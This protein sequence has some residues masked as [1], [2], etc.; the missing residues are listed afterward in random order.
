MELIIKPT[1]LCNFNCEFCSASNLDISHP[2]NGVPKEIKDLILK[3]KPSTIILTGG[4]PL[5][6][7]PDYI[8]EIQE[9]A[10]DNTYISLTSNMKDFYFNPDKWRDV[11]NH[12]HI[13]FITSFNYGHT[14]RWD[15]NTV[16]DE[17][18]FKKVTNKFKEITGGKSLPFIA[19]IDESNEEFIMDHIYLAKELN[20][21]VKING[22]CKLGR[23]GKN[24]PKYKIIKSYIEIIDKGLEKY[25][26]TCSNRKLGQCAFN[27]NF[28]CSSTIRVCY[29][30]SNGKLHYGRCEDEISLGKCGEIPMDENLPIDPKVEI[31]SI[32]DHITNKCSYCELFRFCNGCH[33]HRKHAKEFSEYCGE[34]MKL[35]DD[36][37][38]QGWAI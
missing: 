19:I 38:R 5:M 25:E 4:E 15:E 8:M 30:D 29:I 31:P 10:P 3:M 33:E 16:Y 37:I 11:V 9:L 34:M 26:I 21:K 35:K 2:K 20:T 14:R 13:R 17:N 24:Y 27:T 36:I 12:P 23:Q 6:V 28:M 7:G 32:K 18:M 22:A 1:G